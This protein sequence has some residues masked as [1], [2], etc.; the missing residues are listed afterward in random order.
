MSGARGH[1]NDE[2]SAHTALELR[3][4]TGYHS[5][6]RCCLQVR[7]ILSSYK[8]G[9]LKEAD[10]AAP[11]PA[12]AHLRPGGV[13]AQRFRLRIEGGGL[14]QV[15]ISHCCLFRPG[16]WE[17]LHQL[18]WRQILLHVEALWLALL[19]ACAIGGAG[20]GAAARAGAC[21]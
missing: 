5:S 16:C 20:S 21:P 9:R 15:R 3:E 14:R 12:P 10:S 18:G 13:D 17:V 6:I 19:C 1:D 11:P 2:G 4:L 8:I 7:E